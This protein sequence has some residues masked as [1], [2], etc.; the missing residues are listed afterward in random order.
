MDGLMGDPEFLLEDVP[1]GSRGLEL[2]TRIVQT[3]GLIEEVVGSVRRFFA[4]GQFA[5][6]K[7]VGFG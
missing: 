1:V 7:N 3:L 5:V 6:K 4:A 2:K